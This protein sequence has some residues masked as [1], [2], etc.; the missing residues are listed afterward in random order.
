MAHFIGKVAG[1]GGTASRPGTKAT[2]IEAVVSG[3][4]LGVRVEMNYN[5]EAG[6][7]VATVYLTGGS[8]PAFGSKFL[9]DYRV[10]DLAKVK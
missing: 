4:G 10:A 6:E 7:D 1:S 9:G 3:W 8:H 2:G 5:A